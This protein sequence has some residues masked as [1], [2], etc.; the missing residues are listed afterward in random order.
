MEIVEFLY[1]TREIIDY[2]ELTLEEITKQGVEN[3]EGLSAFV[4]K[5]GEFILLQDVVDFTQ[6]ISVLSLSDEV[7]LKFTCLPK[8]Q[9]LMRYFSE[10]NFVIDE[11]DWLA[12]DFTVYEGISD[13]ILGILNDF[14]GYERVGYI[15]IYFEGKYFIVPTDCNI[16]SNAKKDTIL[17]VLDVGYRIKHE[18]GKTVYTPYFL[19]SETYKEVSYVKDGVYVERNGLGVVDILPYIADTS[20]IGFISEGK[21]VLA[22]EF[23]SFSDMLLVLEE[24]EGTQI[25]IRYVE[26]YYG[27][28]SNKWWIVDKSGGLL[29]PLNE[30]YNN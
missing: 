8:Q 16:L 10:D 29:L 4:V 3:F 17:N 20:D 15:L 21:T 23:D 22:F 14:V 6:F 13:E 25:N 27:K 26:K 7:S 11:S 28:M 9:F 12:L 19:V 2:K 24:V 5:Q 30:R 1:N 18:K